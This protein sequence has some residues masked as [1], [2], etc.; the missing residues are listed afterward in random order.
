MARRPRS[1]TCSAPTSTAR[2]VRPGSCAAGVGTGGPT[3][4]STGRSRRGAGRPARS[5]SSSR[6][7]SARRTTKRSAARTR[8]TASCGSDSSTGVAVRASTARTR[9]RS[10]TCGTG[11]TARSSPRFA[12]RTG[13]R[14]SVSADFVIDAT[15]LEADIREHRLLADLLDHSGAGRNPL[16]RLDVERTFELRGTRSEPGRLYAVGSPTLGGYFAGVD[17]FLGLQYA[18]QAI[19]DDLARQSFCP[20][21]GVGRS[22]SEWWKWALNTKI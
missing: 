18:A 2:K 15:G 16:G 8:H 5:S 7:S 19:T 20:R 6:V 11:T 13:C 17:T 10:P 1:S 3:R 4:G 9:V 21:I 14:S 22:I 12:P